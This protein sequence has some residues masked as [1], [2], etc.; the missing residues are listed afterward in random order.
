[1][2]RLSSYVIAATVLVAMALCP[3][4]AKADSTALYVGNNG[5]GGLS[6]SALFDLRG[7]TLTV[8]LTNTSLGDAKDATGILLAVL[9]N[10]SSTLTPVSASLNG[11]TVYG[12]F[13]SN[14]GEGWQYKSGISA[15]N[16]NSGISATGL[17][18]FGPNGNFY[19][20]GQKLGGSDYGIA[21]VGYTNTGNPS[22]IDPIIQNSIQFTL[23]AASG[24]SLSQL[25][26]SVVF[27]YGTDLS[28]PSFNGNLQQQVPEP[29]V[30]ALL[31]CSALLFGGFLRRPLWS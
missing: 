22:I 15:H 16:K 3:V 30:T 4:A 14:V 26:N 6:A 24:F 2:R 5:A 19:K 1:M 18:I 17:G 29:P 12:S 8:T 23:T 25:G 31:A 28:E 10:A 11:S 27:Q 13:V 9:F 20:T 7:N 21:P